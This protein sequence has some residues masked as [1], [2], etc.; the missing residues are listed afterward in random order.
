MITKY[1]LYTE[2]LKDKMK[3][4]ELTGKKKII[5]NSHKE[6]V[7][8]GINSTEIRSIEDIYYFII[9]HR[10]SYLIVSISMDE[11]DNVWKVEDKSRGTNQDI[12]LIESDNWSDILLSIIKDCY[13]D[14]DNVDIV[15]KDALD[16]LKEYKQEII[17]QVE[18]IE[19]LEKV[20]KYLEVN[21]N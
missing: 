16:V 4:K 19:G 15:I 17:D 12:I 2:S 20:K 13:K 11:D 9:D 1:N 6:L 5:F 10:S 21:D 14:N 8:M 18:Y 3:G 7:D